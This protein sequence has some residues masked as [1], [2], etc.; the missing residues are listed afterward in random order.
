M[1]S[2]GVSQLPVSPRAAGGSSEESPR[3]LRAPSPT[4]WF[5]GRG[6]AEAPWRGRSIPPGT[7]PWPEA[8]PLLRPSPNLQGFA[9]LA[10]RCRLQHQCGRHQF[11]HT[12]TPPHPPPLPPP[13]P[14]VRAAVRCSQK[15]PER[16]RARTCP[17]SAGPESRLKSRQ[18]RRREAREGGVLTRCQQAG[19]A[20]VGAGGRAQR[21]G[22]TLSP[23]TLRLWEQALGKSSP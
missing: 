23:A 12:H 11:F 18:W 3:A 5:L 22:E 1:S 4:L 9:V 2:L 15:P 13:N 16:S 17:D 14:R 19:T 6:R 21:A 20:R 7:A 10:D 8:R